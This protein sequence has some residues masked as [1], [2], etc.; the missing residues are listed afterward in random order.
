MWMDVNGTNQRTVSMLVDFCR[1]IE[2]DTVLEGRRVPNARVDIGF[3]SGPASQHT[4]M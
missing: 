2:C 3:F 4:Q 1:K